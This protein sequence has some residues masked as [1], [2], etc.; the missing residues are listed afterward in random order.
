MA[1]RS[2]LRQ[3]VPVFVVGG[4]LLLAA[5]VVNGS[6]AA[7]RSTLIPLVGF[8]PLLA[9]VVVW[10]ARDGAAAAGERAPRRPLRV[11]IEV[12][13]RKDRL[14][15]AKV[16]REAP[17]DLPEPPAGEPEIPAVPAPA[18]EEPPSAA[19]PEP[20]PP[21]FV[22]TESSSVYHVPDCPHAQKIGAEARVGFPSAAAAK[23]SGRRPC[24]RCC[25][26]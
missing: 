3:A 22:A 17:P 23:K 4:L 5:L 25:G 18:P 12:D 26:E 19:A 21:R 13:S 20:R 15:T 7:G 24:S 2:R 10:G 8:L 14:V 11:S 6:G 16:T 9:V 1:K